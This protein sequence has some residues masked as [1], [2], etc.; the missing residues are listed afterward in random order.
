MMRERFVARV[1][2]ARG[3]AW[4]RFPPSRPVVVDF[5]VDW[6]LTCKTLEAGVLESPSVRD[7]FHREARDPPEGRL[8]PPAA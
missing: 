4:F 3:W 1:G 5:T 7:A 8:H 6:C 2:D